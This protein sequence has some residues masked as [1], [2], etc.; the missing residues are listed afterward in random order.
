MIP[1]RRTHSG[2][3]YKCCLVIPLSYKSNRF[4]SGL[5]VSAIAPKISPALK[6][7]LRNFF[8]VGHLISKYIPIMASRNS[9][10]VR[11][12]L[13]GRAYISGVPFFIPNRVPY[14]HAS[15][16]HGLE[17]SQHKPKSFSRGMGMNSQQNETPSP[18]RPFAASARACTACGGTLLPSGYGL[19]DRAGCV[20]EVACRSCGKRS[21]LRSG[22]YSSTPSGSGV[23]HFLREDTV[24]V[25]R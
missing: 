4:E 24:E 1:L 19:V 23:R 7:G 22:A 5:T 8:P 16:K 18:S 21:T 17:F 10:R 13:Y 20:F 12:P 3:I 14:R 11:R 9:S 6:K 25:V 2:P 15:R